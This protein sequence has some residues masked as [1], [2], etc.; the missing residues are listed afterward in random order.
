M[1][2]YVGA[3]SASVLG[4]ITG[5]AVISEAAQG[6][7]EGT[8]F[9]EVDSSFAGAFSGYSLYDRVYNWTHPGTQSTDRTL[10]NDRS[11]LTQK[12]LK[13]RKMS[14]VPPSMD[15]L[16][17]GISA[18]TFKVHLGGKLKA[19]SRGN[20]FYITQQTVNVSTAGNNSGA[21]SGGQGLGIVGGMLTVPEFTTTVISNDA[22][23]QLG[24]NVFNFNP[25]QKTT[26]SGYTLAT[27]GGMGAES[28][29]TYT[30]GVPLQD[31]I[32]WKST[33]FIYDITNLSN[34]PVF[35]TFYVCKAKRDMP[36]LA[37]DP[38]AS[39]DYG[40]QNFKIG[41]TGA[42]LPA[43]GSLIA[44]E[45]WPT[46]QI[47][48]MVPTSSLRFNQNWQVIKVQPCNIAAGGY[49]KMKFDIE[50]H[51]TYDR[52]LMQRKKAQSIHYSKGCINIMFV[53][54][55][56]PIWSTLAGSTGLKYS[57]A[58]VGMV[59]TR[60]DNYGFVDRHKHWKTAMGWTNQTDGI[61]TDKQTFVGPADAGVILVEDINP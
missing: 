25:D 26:G 10:V 50:V 61:G 43:A 12:K 35:G 36:L 2:Y 11:Q 39:W 18:N 34:V 13:F 54:H 56:V 7:L 33:R 46:S 60:K 37:H 57:S 28:T 14:R 16:P 47:V 24:K 6:A 38:M 32:N 21:T 23:D 40:D 9:T 42:E 20:M 59:V 15:H 19:K 48:H 8:G 17:G 55:G 30:A 5:D 58:E 27:S 51:R 1:A 3:A 52:E 45:Y 29:A 49:C 31:F 41:N 4:F 53:V 44:G 22:L